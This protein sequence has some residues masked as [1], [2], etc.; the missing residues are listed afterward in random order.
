M[1]Q[2]RD[3]KRTLARPAKPIPKALPTGRIHAPAI[4]LA[5]CVHPSRATASMNV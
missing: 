2:H 4:S 3:I 1:S 5:V